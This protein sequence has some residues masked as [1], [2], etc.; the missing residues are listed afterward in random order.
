MVKKSNII[1][2][3]IV[4]KPAGKRRIQRVESPDSKPN[5]VR[6]I[7]RSVKHQRAV[8]RNTK[9]RDNNR[10]KVK[11]GFDWSKVKF[12]SV[13]AKWK[14]ETVFII[15]GGPS[16]KDFNFN[17]LKSKRTI[18]IN[19]A[20]LTYP[21]A[22]VAYWSDS[23][24]YNWYKGDID[25]FKGDKYT[26]KPYGPLTKDIRILKNCGKI[27]LELDPTGIRHGN[28]SGHAAVNLAYHLGAS[29]IVLLGFD[30]RNVGGE[31]HFHDGYPTRKTRDAVYEKNMIPEF[32]SIAEDLKK[33]NVTVINA[34]PGSALTYFRKMTIKQA[35]L[36]S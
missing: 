16:L 33:R 15:G 28:N 12:H 29:T 36:L 35:L 17:S 10:G 7:V 23:R 22:D 30:M 24:V 26:M 20:I 21:Q 2:K 1:R 19:K 5:R 4:V 14:G 8:R 3:K 18:A 32:Y 13:K 27:G 34:C 11:S 9:L 6:P 31:S 25:N